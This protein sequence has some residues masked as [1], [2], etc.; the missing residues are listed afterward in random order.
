[1]DQA[2]KRMVVD[3]LGM[4]LNDYYIIPERC[5]G[6][7]AVVES[8]LNG[9]AYRSITDPRV[10]AE[11]VTEDVNTVLRDDHF[12]VRYDPEAVREERAAGAGQPAEGP[13][14]DE[15]ERN[16]GFAQVRILEGNIGYINMT[17]FHDLPYA[18]DAVDAAMAFVKNTK[19]V[20]IDL[21][22]DHG[23]SSDTGPY[24][25]GYFLGPAPV[26]LYDMYTRDGEGTIHEAFRSAAT[27][28]GT[29]MPDAGL[30]ILTSRFTFSAA[31]AFAYSM[32]SLG[33]GVI[34]GDT[35]GGGAHMWTGK[36]VA[37]GLYAHIPHA[38]PV[39]PRTQGNWE[40]V[41]VVPDRWCKAHE[42]LEV[43]WASALQRLMVTDPG[44]AERYAW[45]LEA[46]EQLRL[47]P[48][49]DHKLA[50]AVVG[51]YGDKRITSENGR[52]FLEWKGAQR[53]LTPLRSDYFV[54]DGFD[55]F[56]V[57]FAPT[58]GG[59]HRLRIVNDDGS[60]REFDRTD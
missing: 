28:K 30:Y 26:L 22:A 46:V 41:G 10:F 27:V 49:L 20:I 17:G 16:F 43:A 48:E 60:Q 56:R 58:E 44:N 42:A 8:K 32:Q 2:Q 3:S 1:M 35:T 5:R 34:V 18:A 36:A 55:F 50:A 19:A 29:P 7:M 15:V 33:R 45:H 54:V 11:R 12:R 37:A 40:G 25:S 57:G 23:G 24:L 52:L 53:A 4:L 51:T 14:P 6:A 59:R 31:E 39:D 9:K 38:R 47:A 13:Y 21:R